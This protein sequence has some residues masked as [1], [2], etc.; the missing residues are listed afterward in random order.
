MQPT[1]SEFVSARLGSGSPSRRLGRMFSRPFTATTFREF[2]RLWN[3]AFAYVLTYFC[4]APLRR[5]V[6]RIVAFVAT[7]SISGFL[8]HDSLVWLALGPQ[9]YPFPVVTVAFT[10]I[11]M[12]VLGCEAIGLSLCRLPR[13]L[14]VACHIGVI[15]GAVAVAVCLSHALRARAA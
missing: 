14:R 3:P 15:V 5:I 1:F 4:Y 10:L 12:L 13:L 11:G 8:L 2:W 6:P 7:F 9:R